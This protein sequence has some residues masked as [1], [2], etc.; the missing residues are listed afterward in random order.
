MLMH[1]ID[2]SVN[3]DEGNH[4]PKDSSVGLCLS[5]SNASTINKLLNKNFLNNRRFPFDG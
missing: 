3:A 4:T 1:Q 2:Q 5:A